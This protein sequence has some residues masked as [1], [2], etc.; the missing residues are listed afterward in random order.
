M[1]FTEAV[2]SGFGNYATFDGRAPRSAYWYWFLF[3][4]LV[5]VAGSILDALA[6]SSGVFYVLSTLAL[7]LPGLAVGVR[8]LHDVDKSGWNLL[9][10]FV[11]L[12]GF[13][14]LYL[15]VQPSTAGLNE[16]G[17]EPA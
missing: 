4:S 15:Y 8:R 14:V 16:Y 1:S 13:Y 5:M 11:P 10:A 9:W 12:A 7:F 6:G 2:S 3:S 17:D